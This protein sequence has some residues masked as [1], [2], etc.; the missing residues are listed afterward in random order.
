MLQQ[1]YYNFYTIF[2]DIKKYLL[3]H[4][5]KKKKMNALTNLNVMNLF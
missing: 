1:K 3:L 4:F 2:F 5:D